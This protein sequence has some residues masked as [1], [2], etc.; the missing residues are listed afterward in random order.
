MDKEKTTPVV[1]IIVPVYNAQ[2]YLPI[3]VDSI[4][5]Q[6]YT[7]FE[8]LLIDDGSK[9]N[10]LEIC[11]KYADKDSRVKVF[12]KENGGVSSARNCGLEHACGKYITFA[13]SDDYMFADCIDTM[14]KE[15]EGYDLLICNYQK[16]TR[17]DFN[18][19]GIYNKRNVT[20]EYIDAKNIKEMADVV[21]KIGYKNT[22]VWNQLFLKSIIEEHHIR[23]EYIEREDEL[24]SFTY[25][26]YINSV[27]R[28][29]FEGYT[30]IDTPCSVSKAHSYLVEK[31]RIDKMETIYENIFKRFSIS[32]KGFDA[33][34]NVRIVLSMSRY[35]MK[36][37]YK[38]TRV[39]FMK[40]IS[41]WKEIRN[42][43]W[44]KTRFVLKELPRFDATIIAIAKSRL[45]WLLDPFLV[46]FGNGLYYMK[47]Q[48]KS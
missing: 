21:P 27:K 22:S 13:D 10:S 25:F 46:L 16:A 18:I 36:G 48:V 12:H 44:V 33:T 2:R 4:L 28:S 47:A 32:N 15:C 37:Y 20:H 40:R 45:Y 23:F 39:P 29:F 30:Y 6:S 11:N 17:E 5:A 7:G 8:L 26:Q 19:E 42:D 14:V 3:T 34:V 41:R 24:F 43:N 1:S 38:D 35:I 9:D 31:D